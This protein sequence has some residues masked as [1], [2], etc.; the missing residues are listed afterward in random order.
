MNQDDFLDELA[1]L[2]LGSRLKRISDQLSAQAAQVYQVFNMPLNP[3]WF[4]LLALL[5]K[6]EQVSVVDASKRL[7]LSQPAL[8]QFCQELAR[9]KLIKFIKDPEDKRR[10]LVSLTK[11]GRSTL[12]D[13]Q[14]TWRAVR[15]AAEAMCT[16]SGNQFYQS[17]I[18]FE[19]ALERM[20]LVE[21]T[22]SVHDK[23]N[24]VGNIENDLEFLPFT[25]ALAPHFE[26]INKI[27]IEQMFRLEDIDKRVLAD[28]QKYIID[29]GG[30][31][32]FARH[33]QMG[34]VGTCALLRSD[35]GSFELTKMGVTPNCRG[36]KVG[37][38]L[39]Q[40]VIEQALNIPASKL[41]LLTNSKCEAAIHLYEKN[42]FYHD[43]ETMQRYG[44]NYERCNVAMRYKA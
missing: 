1:E 14:P 28:P 23:I 32:F 12:S 20:S 34:V 11:K 29:N 7:G 27:W 41:Y 31:V 38:R 37:E 8:S 40:Y 6:Y 24:Q 10:R 15:K 42:G 19:R 22:L 43:D 2:A 36:L 9:A 17:L 30:Y 44:K 25:P 18:N 39:L 13:V 16:E 26:S 35:A 5:D 33:R 21:R 3:K 4:P